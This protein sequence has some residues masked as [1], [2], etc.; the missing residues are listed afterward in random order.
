MNVPLPLRVMTKSYREVLIS[1][2]EERATPLS[3][4]YHTH[5]SAIYNPRYG[6]LLLHALKDPVQ[7]IAKKHL[8]P[9]STFGRIATNGAE[10]HPHTDRP[11]LHWAVTVTLQSDMP[12]PIK[13]L[14]NGKWITYETQELQGVLINSGTVQH[15]RLPFE[16]TKAIALFVFYTEDPDHK[17]D[18][19]LKTS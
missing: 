8:Y 13:V 2:I 3:T 11:G 17:F 7:S 14:I 5:T 1:E 19:L 16:G 10:L 15:R 4:T 12:W 6:R 9:V 18:R